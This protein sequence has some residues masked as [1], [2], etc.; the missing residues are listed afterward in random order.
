MS[1]LA[2]LRSR[3]PDG[4]V[5]ILKRSPVGGVAR[6]IRREARRRARR[7]APPIV[8]SVK[9]WAATRDD[10]DCRSIRAAETTH[11]RPPRT[12]EAT[13]DPRFVDV[14][15]MQYTIPE[16]YLCRIPNARLIGEMGLVVLPDGAFTS[17]VTFSPV[18]LVKQEAYFTPLPRRVHRKAGSYFSLLSLWA[19]QPNY[20]HWLHDSMMRLHLV[21]P[22]LPEDVRFIVP[23]NLRGFQRDS[24]AVVG[25][26]DDRICEYSGKELWEL[27]TL[28]FAP[29]TTSSGSNSPAAIEWFRDTA[30]SACDLSPGTPW[31]RI[32]ISRR[33]TAYRRIA[34]EPE[35]EDVLGRFGFETYLL[36]ELTFREQVELLSETAAVVSA[37]GAGLTN[38]LFAPPGAKVLVMVDPVQISV[39]FW[40]MSEAAG[41]EYWY[42]L[43]ET[44]P[45]VVG[46]YDPDVHVEPERLEHALHAM[47]G[48]P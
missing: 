40:T 31:R 35:I 19:H 25:I 22:E 15:G 17:E 43:G 5:R 48:A 6:V 14:A 26:T 24:L 20:Y 46:P 38:L 42:M 7:V 30:W 44:V 11:R 2:R 34:N 21:L 8:E 36:E 29:P 23:A 45:G 33:L 41:H 47:F 27:E 10:V 32:Y 12:I 39:F 1:P 9:A 28:Y 3:V 4:A 16:K 13:V 18:H 37:S